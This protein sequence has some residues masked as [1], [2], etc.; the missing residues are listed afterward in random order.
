MPNT[1]PGRGSFDIPGFEELPTDN[2]SRA[3]LI[4][5]LLGGPNDDV[6]NFVPLYQSTN[7]RP[8]MLTFEEA[9]RATVRDG[10]VVDMWVIPQFI[11]NDLVPVGII[12]RARG[13]RGF[14]LDITICNVP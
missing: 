10:E 1:R 2:R 7:N 14:A 12:I 13:D 6:R 3:H 11:D 5:H 4:G 9:V 8:N